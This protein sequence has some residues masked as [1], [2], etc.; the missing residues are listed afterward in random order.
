MMKW[1]AVFL[2]S[3]NLLA[4]EA[5]PPPRKLSLNEAI[6]IGLREA[7]N[8]RKASND[9][10]LSGKQVL[11]GYGQFLPNLAGLGTYNY[12]SGKQLYA[13]T[14]VT[15][16]DSRNTALNLQLGT[17]LNLFNG[18]S[19]LASLKSALATRQ[20]SE[21]TLARAK[22]DIIIDVTQSF[23]QV[24]LDRHLVQIA[25]QNLQTSREREN[26][27]RELTRVGVKNQAD[28]LRQRAQTSQ[29]E[30]Y[31]VNTKNK[32]RDDQVLLLRKLRLNPEE[33]YELTEPAL[34]ATVQ[35]KLPAEDDLAKQALEKRPDL[36]AYQA[37][38]T[39]ADWDT[40]RARGNYWPKLDLG[41][42]LFSNGA[43]FSQ[44]VV[45]G[46]NALPPS[47]SP[48]SSQLGDQTHYV[49]GLTLTWSIFDRFLTTLDVE[50]AAVTADNSR[51]DADDRRL[52]VVGDVRRVY[53]D[54]QSAWT[55]LESAKTGQVAAE[56]AFLTV[57]GRYRVGSSNFVD[58][59]AAQTTLVQSRAS[60]VQAQINA[61]LQDKMLDYLTG[62]LPT[63]AP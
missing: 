33:P 41:L 28:Y 10:E 38:A 32:L 8:V 5:P 53:G 44:L 43:T 19:D 35:R 49:V 2:V 40:T 3:T 13:V 61:I 34:D 7:T 15:I 4:A 11:Q 14:G 50:R 31:D 17:T 27:L 21:L 18:L 9:T 24:V 20:S 46:S 52:E 58:V 30:L 62:V 12:T 47:Q 51:L 37:R 48:I 25:D 36:Q 63:A 54:Y 56:E 60:R 1:F 45:N 16:V 29:D 42:T 59:L 23:L 22:Q 39:A 57:Q 6:G 26:Q 55:Q